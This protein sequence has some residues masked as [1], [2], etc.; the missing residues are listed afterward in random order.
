MRPR[1]RRKCVGSAARRFRQKSK[2]RPVGRERDSDHPPKLEFRHEACLLAQ[3]DDR[4]PKARMRRHP[5]RV[6]SSQYCIGRF[7]CGSPRSVSRVWSR[8]RDQPHQDWTSRRNQRR[9]ARQPLSAQRTSCIL[10]NSAADSDHSRLAQVTVGSCDSWSLARRQRIPQP[11]LRSRAA[12]PA[13]D[14][15][16]HL[17]FQA[18]LDVIAWRSAG[19]KRIRLRTVILGWKG[20]EIEFRKGGCPLQGCIFGSA[21]YWFLDIETLGL[22]QHSKRISVAGAP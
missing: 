1:L 18:D 12:R 5:C 9:A 4:F 20:R 2:N 8:R 6:K 16:P 10:R 3:A 7:L 14:S 11:M 13:S 17:S 15:T 21:R 19:Q 22:E